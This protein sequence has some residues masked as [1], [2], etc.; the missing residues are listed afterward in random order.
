VKPLRILIVDDSTSSRLMIKAS[1]DQ[2]PERHVDQ[3]ENGEVGVTSS[4]STITIWC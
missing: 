4:R 3:A 1:L 2:I